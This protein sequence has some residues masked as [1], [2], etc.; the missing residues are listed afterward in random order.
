VKVNDRISDTRFEVF[1]EGRKYMKKRTIIIVVGIALVLA[2]AAFGIVSAQQRKTGEADGLQTHEVAYG[3]LS[4]VVDETGEVY[5]D[6]SAMLYWETTGV[7]GEVQVSLNENV[8]EDQVLASLKEDSLP[9]NN[10]LAKQELISAERALED[11]YDNAATTGAN[12]QL[13]VANALE[14]LDDAEYY[15][16]LHQ[17]GNRAS[18]EELKAAKAKLQIA[19]KRLNKK[20]NQHKKAQ[21]GIPRAQ[22]QIALTEAINQYQHA[23]WYVR[24]LQEGADEIEMAI[25][26]ANVSVATAALEAAEKEYER[27]KDGPDPE[28]IE[29]AEARIAAAQATLDQA[30]ITAPFSGVITSV[31]ILPGDLVAPSTLA[32]RIDH[33]QNLLVD[34]SVSEVDIN[35]IDVGQPV[36]LEFDAIL[37]KEYQGEVVEVSPVGIQEQGLVSFK[38]TIQLIDADDEVR[39]GL[40]AAVQ[41]VV[42]QVND[43]LLIPNRA[44]RWVRGEQVVYLAQDKANI[45]ETNLEIVPVTLGASSDE[46]SELIEGDITE[47]DLVVLNPPSI[48]IFEEMEP[49]DGPP[50]GF[51]GN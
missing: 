46:F 27:V 9:Q 40:T 17:P 11:L 31:D 41:I 13:A 42:R 8:K 25:L 12:A 33:L 32:F 45:V 23:D 38:V 7:V 18:T 47:G 43:A 50:R 44:V 2:I 6:Q 24:W 26:D 3:D 35:Q 1:H 15:W 20:R 28:E 49:G 4:A 5:A 16:T 48:S 37:G 10:F 22:A 30:S 51:E 29:L 19:E 39:S 21:K 34:V 36:T 14:A